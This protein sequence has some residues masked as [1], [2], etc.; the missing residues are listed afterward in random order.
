MMRIRLSPQARTDL[1]ELWIFIARES[2]SQA[3]ATRV[4]AAITDKFALF[5]KFPFIGKSLDTSKHP[6]LRSFPVD[7]Y[8]IFYSTRPGEIRILRIIHASRDA[9]AVFDRE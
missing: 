2:A 8:V 1:D 6:N 3:L 4:V 5:A 7:H 9:W